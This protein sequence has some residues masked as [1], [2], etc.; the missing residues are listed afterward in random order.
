MWHKLSALGMEDFHDECRHTY[1][2]TTQHTSTRSV[3]N[4]SSHSSNRPQWKSMTFYLKRPIVLRPLCLGSHDKYVDNLGEYNKCIPKIRSP[5]LHFW[6]LWVKVQYSHDNQWH[7]Q[8]PIYPSPF[9]AQTVYLYKQM[10]SFGLEDFH[11]ECGPSIEEVPKVHH[12][13]QFIFCQ[14]HI[15]N[16]KFQWQSI[17]CTL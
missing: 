11:H 10:V 8:M 4:L 7:R 9:K 16:R 13:D 1:W 14:S 12:P 6:I 3:W 15:S 2:R 5:S 17:A